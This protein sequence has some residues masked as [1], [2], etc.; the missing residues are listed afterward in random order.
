[1]VGRWYVM[2]SR[3]SIGRLIIVAGWPD[4]SAES[5]AMSGAETGRSSKLQSVLAL[6]PVIGVGSDILYLEKD[7]KTRPF[8]QGR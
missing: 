4:C 6:D 1:M 2:L 3:I 5:C 8:A 7:K